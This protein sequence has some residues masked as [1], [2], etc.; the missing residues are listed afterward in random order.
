MAATSGLK[1]VYDHDGKP[2]TLSLGECKVYN[3]STSAE[4]WTKLKTACSQFLQSVMPYQVGDTVTFQDALV[5][6]TYS[7]QEQSAGG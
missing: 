2:Y 5:T 6:T 1:I 7:A 3:D 4:D